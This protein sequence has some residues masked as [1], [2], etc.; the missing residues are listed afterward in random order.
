MEELISLPNCVKS[1]F[2]LLSISTSTS[3]VSGLLNTSEDCILYSEISLGP[4]F[5]EDFT[6]LKSKLKG[7]S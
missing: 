5:L 6:I 4:L 2:L 3:Y 7:N 1:C